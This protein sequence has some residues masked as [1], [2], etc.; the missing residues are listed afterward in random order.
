MNYSAYGAR[1]KPGGTYEGLAPE[2][3]SGISAVRR[4]GVLN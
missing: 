2:G 3:A 1:A 4:R